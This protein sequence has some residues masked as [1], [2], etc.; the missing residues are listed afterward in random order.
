M[1]LAAFIRQSITAPNAFIAPGYP[2]GVMPTTFA[3]LGTHKIDGL[4]AFIVSGSH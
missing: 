3:A 2:K 1:A 4:V